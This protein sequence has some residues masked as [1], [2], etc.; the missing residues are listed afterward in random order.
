MARTIQIP[1]GIVGVAY[2]TMQKLSKA[3]GECILIYNR[4]T[5]TDGPH[6]NTTTNTAAY[7]LEDSFE[8]D[9]GYV[10]L[11]EERTGSRWEAKV[12]DVKGTFNGTSV[13]VGFV[14]IPLV[15]TTSTDTVKI[16]VQLWGKNLTDYA[17]V[18]FDWVLQE[19]D[20]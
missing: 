7:A 20:R 2:R 5:G 1:V 13:Q 12:Y 14:A 4:A 6:T 18:T 19:L 17:G 15:S 11:K 8:I 10:P 3:I 16:L 9:T